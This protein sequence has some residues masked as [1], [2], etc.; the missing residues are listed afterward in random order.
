M[1]A[2]KQKRKASAHTKSNKAKRVQSTGL[3]ATH[4]KMFF[5]MGLFLVSLGVYLLTFKSQDNAMFGLAM[6]SLLTGVVTAF[7]A[8]FTLAK[9][10]SK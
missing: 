9:N 7:Y 2:N 5:L 1:P 8:K 6:I 10:K 4:P 3:M